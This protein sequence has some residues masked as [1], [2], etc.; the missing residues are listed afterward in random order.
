MSAHRGEYGLMPAVLAAIALGLGFLCGVLYL[1]LFSGQQS[2]TLVSFF[3]LG[4][5]VFAGLLGAFVGGVA[6]GGAALGHYVM[7][8]LGRGSVLSR[9]L[10]VA[11]GSG[12][13]VVL[14]LDLVLLPGSIGAGGEGSSPSF[15]EFDSVAFVIVAG[16]SALAFGLGL[17][18]RR[19][20]PKAAAPAT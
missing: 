3:A 16:T 13:V 6:A 9:S 14:V 18:W 17:A 15:L 7:S 4:A 20:H 10:G 1:I 11:L 12:L 8:R 19:T 5:E 2:H